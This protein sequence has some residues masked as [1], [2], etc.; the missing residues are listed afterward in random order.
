[1]LE[2][3]L[4]KILR[5]YASYVSCIL[6]SVEE[7]NIIPATLGS[8]LLN[9]PALGGKGSQKLT[10]LSGLRDQLEKAISVDKIFNILSTEYASFL[11]YD[12]F[13]CIIEEYDID[14]N[15]PKMKYPEHLKAFINQH[16]LVEFME[17]NPLLK[18][19]RDSSKD[20]VLKIDIESTCT[21]ARLKDL[22]KTFASIM[23]LKKSAL[24]IL[25]VEEGCVIVTLLIPAHIASFIFTGE[26][27]TSK[28]KEEFQ[29]NSVL[30]LKC[31]SIKYEFFSGEQTLNKTN[32][33]PEITTSVIG[34]NHIAIDE[35][36]DFIQ[37]SVIRTHP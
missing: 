27:F 23:G 31:N 26:K 33:I 35:V 19:F 36:K 10:L 3:N 13:E 16:K 18:D 2:I 9:L 28:Q 37:V 24:R 22:T 21:L 25:D 5:R 30:W 29:S 17:I 6:R 34:E 12:I 1:M 15:R 32:G 14:E 4:K 20:L 11:D 7:L 8:F